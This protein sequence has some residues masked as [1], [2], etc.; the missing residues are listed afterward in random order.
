M[1]VIGLYPLRINSVRFTTVW[2]F[3]KVGVRCRFT[4]VV[5]SKDF[6]EISN[7][8]FQ[9]RNIYYFTWLS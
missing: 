6:F 4:R 2:S 9:F 1:A 8:T 3:L 7:R 5:I